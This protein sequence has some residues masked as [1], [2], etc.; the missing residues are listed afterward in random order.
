[1]D[2]QQNENLKTI[3]YSGIFL[4]CFYE[5]SEKC[6]EAAP[7][8]ILVYLYSVNKSSKIIKKGLN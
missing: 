6:I 7:E 4:S 5:K 1:M 2:V 8:H 3:S